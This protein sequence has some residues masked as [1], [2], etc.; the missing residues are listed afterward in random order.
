MIVLLFKLSLTAYVVSALMK[1]EQIFAWYARLL[2]KLP[3]YLAN[4]LG[5]CFKC[6]TG[7]VCLWGYLIAYYNDYNLLNH[8]FFISAG[9]FLS[10]IYN[11][12]WEICEQ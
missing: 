10:L 11:K 4:P 12:I 8:V 6:F 2:D 1:P 5:Y 9:I 3:Y 7:Q